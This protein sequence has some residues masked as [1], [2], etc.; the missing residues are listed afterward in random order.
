M[1][2]NYKPN[3]R[4]NGGR[5]EGA[6]RPAGSKNALALGEVRAIKAAG[7]R[8][9]EAATQ[10]QRELADEMLGVITEVARGKTSFKQAPHRFRAA[11]HIREEI[12]GT[13]KQ[14]IEVSASDSFAET[15]RL[16]RERALTRNPG[17][18]GQTAK[19]AESK[20]DDDAALGPNGERQ[21]E[22]RGP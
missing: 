5:R 21:G 20:G 17:G 2:R 3:G 12:C 4:P 16:A 1:P 19:A 22:G 11:A 6:G 18:A 13:M 10:E 8:V 14:K 9:P 15:L 7:L